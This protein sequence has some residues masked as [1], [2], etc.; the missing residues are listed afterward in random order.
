MNV[1]L[2]FW[3]QCTLLLHSLCRSRL[4]FT[5]P[6]HAPQHWSVSCWK[7]FRGA[8]FET[9]WLLLGLK[10]LGSVGTSSYST[11]TSQL[12]QGK[13]V[14]VLKIFTHKS[15][16]F[17]FELTPKRLWPLSSKATSWIFF[18]SLVIYRIWPPLWFCSWKF[19]KLGHVLEFQVGLLSLR[20]VSMFLMPCFYRTLTDPF[21]CGLHDALL[22]FVNQLH[23]FV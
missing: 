6:G 7:L 13:R 12:N 10:T 14:W 18:D 21:R 19:G 22:G 20:H 15:R 11:S 2:Y 4:I 8:F 9:L 23:F 16:S 5:C 1:S 3:S 17:T